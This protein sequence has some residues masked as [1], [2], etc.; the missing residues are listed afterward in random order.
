MHDA[1]LTIETKKA[2]TSVQITTDSN[3]SET[4][5]CIPEGQGEK[6]KKSGRQNLAAMVL[7][8]SCLSV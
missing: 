4:I 3:L 7:L 5:D 6:S 2:E 8:F 1:L